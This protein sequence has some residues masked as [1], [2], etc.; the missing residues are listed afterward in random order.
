MSIGPRSDV[1]QKL[2]TDAHPSY[3]ESRFGELHFGWRPLH[4]LRDGTWKYIDGPE[5]ELFQVTVDPGEH[6]NRRDARADAASGMA[7][8]LEDLARRGEGTASAMPA[9]NSDVAER[10]RSLGY[11]AGRQTLG[12]AGRAGGDNGDPKLEIVRY[13]KYVKTF[14][15]GLVNL[16]S[17]R[18]REAEVIFRRLAREFPLAFEPHQYLARTLAARRAFDDA[19]AELEVAI[20]LS[21]REA[22]LYF[23]QARTLAD[24]AQFDRALARVADGRRLEPASYN[25]ALTEGLVARAAGDTARAE[26]AF[27]EAVRVNPTLAIAHLEIG[28]IA[29]AR[30]DRD[31]ARREYQAAVEGDATLAAARDALDRISR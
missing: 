11:V 12:Q 6:E 10:L 24:E 18:P 8:V 27:H 1:Q 2:Q 3:A 17:G 20:R 25:G 28:Q 7:R 9:A 19:V 21:P 5:P 13:E 15:D 4:S 16:E 29:E 26:R 23:D 30:G 22:V 14:N 31:A